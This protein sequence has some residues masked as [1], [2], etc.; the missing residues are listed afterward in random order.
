MGYTIPTPPPSPVQQLGQ[1][2]AVLG[3]YLAEAKRLE[4][5]HV[6]VD[7]PPLTEVLKLAKQLVDL[8]ATATPR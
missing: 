4:E 6:P 8:K 2:H 3:D 5:A 1:A 7:G